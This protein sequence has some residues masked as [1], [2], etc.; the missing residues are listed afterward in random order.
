MV[1]ALKAIY[2]FVLLKINQ[3]NLNTRFS[4]TPSPMLV[5]KIKD[6]LQL[7]IMLYQKE[8]SLKESTEGSSILQETFDVHYKF[9][10]WI[11][12]P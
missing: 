3:E 2:Y 4:Y 12:R 10:L 7:W 8:L 6:A 5:Y 9:W 11:G 1:I